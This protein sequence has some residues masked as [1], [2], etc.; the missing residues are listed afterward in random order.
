MC[1]VATEW[2]WSVNLAPK[3]T[4]IAVKRLLLL[5]IAEC[6]DVHN[7]DAKGTFV[8]IGGMTGNMAPSTVRKGLAE[9]AADGI[10]EG[11]RGVGRYAETIWRPTANSMAPF[12][13]AKPRA[14]HWRAYQVVWRGGPKE[15]R[16]LTWQSRLVMLAL[17][18]FYGNGQGC[19]PSVVTAAK[20][21]GLGRQRM[22]WWIN[23]LARGGYLDI[24]RYALDGFQVRNRYWIEGADAPGMKTVARN[25]AA[26]QGLRCTP[27]RHAGVHQGDMQE[28][29]KA[30]ENYSSTNHQSTRTR[31]NSLREFCADAPDTQNQNDDA[32]GLRQL[33][34]AHRGDATGNQAGA[35]EPDAQQGHR[36]RHCQD[37]G[38]RSHQLASEARSADSTAQGR[39]HPPRPPL[40]A[41][42]LSKKKTPPD[43]AG[44]PPDGYATW[45]DWNRANAP[46]P[47][48]AAG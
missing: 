31:G 35:F 23:Q 19:W 47:K 22:S 37:D 25:Q 28:S 20:V 18:R 9:L 11:V 30:T 39:S 16:T 44:P 7:A 45:G 1:I 34:Q 48:H 21:V 12:K 2:A 6:T 8:T 15:Q 32:Q 10:I 24:D 27:R 43:F 26:A 46:K 36:G 42:R 41:R 13:D 40:K 17:A 38:G 3:P 33:G 4:S 5:A 29:V 14:I